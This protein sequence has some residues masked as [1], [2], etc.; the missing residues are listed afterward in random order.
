MLRGEL[1]CPGFR[2]GKFPQNRKTH[3]VEFD[4]FT[5]DRIEL[6]L[7]GLAV[8][9]NGDDEFILTRHIHSGKYADPVN[10]EG[11]PDPLFNRLNCDLLPLDV[12]HVGNTAH[13]SNSPVSTTYRPVARVEKSIAENLRRGLLI[14]EITSAIELGRQD[15]QI[16]F[17]ARRTFMTDLETT[18][19]LASTIVF[20]A[21]SCADCSRSVVTAQDTF[22]IPSSFIWVTLC[23]MHQFGITRA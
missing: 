14:V 12:E 7:R 9:L 17:L 3:F 22:L 8:G 11:L 5:A 2:A 6:L 16:A 1:F 10:L 15:A 23:R 13:D 18:I 20:P 21:T 19:I 4:K